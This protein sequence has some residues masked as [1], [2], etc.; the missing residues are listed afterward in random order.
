MFGVGYDPH[1]A[2]TKSDDVDMAYLAK[3]LTSKRFK[4]PLVG[5]VTSFN[6]A[7]VG[8]AKRS[9]GAPR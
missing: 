2:Q 3:I 1:F 9:F 7:L 6:Q 5:N 4:W 8:T